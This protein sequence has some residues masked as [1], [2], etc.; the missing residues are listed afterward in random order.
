LSSPVPFF[1]ARSIFLFGVFSFFAFSIA[2]RKAGLVSGSPP[3]LAAIVI[4]FACF[5]KIFP[6][7]NHHL[8]IF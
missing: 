5:V 3:F 1:I 2:N 4:K 7:K 8:T 6:L